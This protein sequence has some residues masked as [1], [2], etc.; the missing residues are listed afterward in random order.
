MNACEQQGT[1]ADVDHQY[2]MM[3]YGHICI[4]MNI[5]EPKF[6]GLPIRHLPLI[7]LKKKRDGDHT[8]LFAHHAIYAWKRRDMLRA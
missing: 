4:F 2:L 6:V 8:R 5:R 3:K 7:I 1:W